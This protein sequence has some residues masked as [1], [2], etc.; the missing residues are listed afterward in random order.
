MPDRRP[1]TAA[2]IGAG[3]LG[4][5]LVDRLTRSTTLYCA[6][7]V[8]R[9]GA[10]TGLRRAAEM[11]VATSTAGV[12]AISSRDD[13]EVVFDASDAAA[14]ST[15]WPALRGTDVLLVNLTPSGAGQMVVPTVN[16]H[17][18][19]TNR[20]LNLITC[21][22]Q[23]ALPILAAIARHCSPDY[24]EI[25]TTA[26]SATV[27]P[28]A[29]R[30]L[31]DY[32]DTTAFAAAR[33]APQTE[34]KVLTFISPAIP[35]PAFRVHLTVLARDLRAEALR[36]SI[37]L[38]ANE[39]RGFAPGYEVSALTLEH[40]RVTA[41]MTV[42]AHS[43]RLPA[44]AGNVEIINAAAVELAERHVANLELAGTP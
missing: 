15:H 7:V 23:A 44:F 11:G 29:R 33:L 20:H 30:N 25:V 37:R 9:P 18:A 19:H 28:A 6:L 3:L 12:E 2:V 34:V 35:A 22:G 1:R 39:V 32:L 14:N 13:I 41:T 4:I 17:Q 21:G 40:G 16:G 26:A 5:D 8:G 24:A 31:D 36:E 10:S 27:G 38:A 43:P 42:T